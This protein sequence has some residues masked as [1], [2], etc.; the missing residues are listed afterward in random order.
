MKRIYLGIL[1]AAIVVLLLMTVGVGETQL[2]KG[3]KI[4]FVEQQRVLA[5]SQ[6]GKDAQQQLQN[7]QE[8]KQAEIDRREK[9]L[10]ELDEKI[11][12]EML[13][14]TAEARDK[15]RRDQRKIKAE[16]DMFISEAYDEAEVLS[17]KNAKAIQK[18]VSDTA[19][20]IAKEMG[21]S[22]ILERMGVVL[23]GNPDYD[24]T[25]E[26]I[27]RIDQRTA[28]SAASGAE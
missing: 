27:K 13:P 8:K 17:R 14:L 2:A 26:M 7:L 4:G 9:E 5:E 10:K 21:Y 24:L 19:A 28:K 25:D 18:L 22:V 12:N 1:T 16:L 20:E 23:Y 15:L 6:I 3:M 11:S